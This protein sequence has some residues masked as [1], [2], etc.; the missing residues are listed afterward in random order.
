MRT[1]VTRQCRYIYY[2]N[3]ISPITLFGLGLLAVAAFFLTL[4]IFLGA[5]VVFGVAAGYLAWRV[6]KTVRTIEKEFAARRDAGP[7]S[8]ARSL[9]I[10]ITPDRGEHDMH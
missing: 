5:L 10:D 7:V 3:G 4:P 8:D 2:R 6:R 1:D 9:T